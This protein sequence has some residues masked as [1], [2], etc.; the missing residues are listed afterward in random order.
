M[1]MMKIKIR[2]RIIWWI[3][4]NS[5]GNINLILGEKFFVDYVSDIENMREELY[6]IILKYVYKFK[7]ITNLLEFQYVHF[8]LLKRIYFYYFE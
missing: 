8:V 3:Y 1:K 4:D 2:K 5:H 6:E 7:N